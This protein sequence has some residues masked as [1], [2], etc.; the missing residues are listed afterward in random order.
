MGN[1]WGVAQKSQI[2]FGHFYEELGERYRVYEKKGM[3]TAAYTG[4]LIWGFSVAGFTFY[5]LN[6]RFVIRKMISF[7]L[8]SNW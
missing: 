2:S 6:A 4:I 5:A 1:L 3:S 8:L 7:N